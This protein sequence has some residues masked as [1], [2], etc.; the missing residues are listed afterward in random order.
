MNVGSRLQQERHDAN[1]DG[2]LVFSKKILVAQKIP[3][4]VPLPKV[5]FYRIRT[6]RHLHIAL[7]AAAQAH[8]RSVQHSAGLHF[9]QI[10]IPQFQ[11]MRFHDSKSSHI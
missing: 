5:P 7:Q 8:T 1:G 10:Q 9:F 3:Y 4:L 6:N 2:Q 11:S